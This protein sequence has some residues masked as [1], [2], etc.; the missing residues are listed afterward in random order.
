MV[1]VRLTG[2]GGARVVA[3]LAGSLLVL[4]VACGQEKVNVDAYSLSEHYHT[5]PYR[6]LRHR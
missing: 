3:L 6:S 4:P 2:C 1:A 5:T